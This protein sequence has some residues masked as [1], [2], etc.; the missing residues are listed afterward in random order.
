[1][2]PTEPVGEKLDK[3]KYFVRPKCAGAD[4]WSRLERLYLLEINPTESAISID[5]IPA[6]RL[7]ALNRPDS[8]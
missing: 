4:K 5:R 8:F 2:T 6:Q 3:E 1:L 7:F